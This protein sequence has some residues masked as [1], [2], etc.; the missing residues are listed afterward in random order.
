[1]PVAG[2]Y[3]ITV[4]DSK[5]QDRLPGMPFQYV[6][7]PGRPVPWQSEAKFGSSFS[8]EGVIMAGRPLE[9]AVTLKDQHGNI[10]AGAYASKAGHK[11]SNGSDHHA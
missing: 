1:M 9:I 2:T 7:M 3:D 8:K 6:S 5:S 11:L 10:S 4:L